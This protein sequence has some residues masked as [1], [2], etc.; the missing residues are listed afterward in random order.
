MP[1]ISSAQMSR[2]KAKKEKAAL[3]LE[4]DTLIGKNRRRETKAPEEPCQSK[5]HKK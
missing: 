1:T 3:E 5:R 4:K 2:S